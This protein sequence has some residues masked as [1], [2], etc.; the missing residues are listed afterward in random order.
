MPLIISSAEEL[1]VTAGRDLATTDW[2][3][4]DQSRI[5]AFANATGDHQWIHV[6]GERARHGPFGGPIAHGYLLLSLV[7]LLLPQLIE[8]SGATMGVNYGCDKVRFPSA[9]RSGARIR[10]RGEVLSTEAVP[11]G[12]HVKIRM[13]I[14]AEG[15]PK[16]GCVVETLSR[17]YFQ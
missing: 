5:D 11:G 15:S 14:E 1:L 17:W 9:V 16:P 10:G 2:L 8:V 13:T 12:V 3:S 6:D 4:I 7:S